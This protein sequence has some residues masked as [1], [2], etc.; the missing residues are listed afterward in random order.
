NLTFPGEAII[1]LAAGC[2]I[3]FN[4]FSVA[5]VARPM[6][7]RRNLTFPGEAIIRLAAGCYIIFNIFSAASVARPMTRRPE[8]YL[9]W[10]FHH[11]PS[12]GMLLF[13]IG[14]PA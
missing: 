10:R 5:S 4:F 6:T 1:R 9:P 2:Y 13:L 11:P 8:S 14:C 12:G 3:V 7:R